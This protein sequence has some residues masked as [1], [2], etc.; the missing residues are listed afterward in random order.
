MPVRLVVTFS[1]RIARASVSV[2]GRIRHH[3]VART[4][5]MTAAN[6]GK[7]RVRTAGA[8]RRCVAASVQELTQ[9]RP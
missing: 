9:S 8:T 2:S 4:M 6:A 1:C 7:T 3:V 5:Q